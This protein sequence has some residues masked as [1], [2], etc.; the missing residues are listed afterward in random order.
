M[1]EFAL[2][3]PCAIILSE[4]DFP[5]IWF[6]YPLTEFMT[7]VIFALTR[8]FT[9][10]KTEYDQ[11]RIL[12]I[13]IDNSQDSIESA[14]SQS[15]SFCESLGADTKQEFAVTL[16]IEEIC[17]SIIRNAMK[18]MPGGKIRITLNAL[19]NGDFALNILD[20]AV[21]FNP[22]SFM[23]KKI[24]NENDFDIDEIS[25]TMIKSKTKKL[26]YRKSSGFNSLSVRI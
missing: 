12:R 6:M 1:R 26:M 17:M 4:F 9:V 20:N 16:V 25:M 23:T 15:R 13:M 18:N 8:R 7:S 10:K 19:E 2:F 5:A 3:I 24:K 11:S 21:E 14:L 22:F